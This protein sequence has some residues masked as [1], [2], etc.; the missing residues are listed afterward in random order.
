MHMHNSSRY[1]DR[2]ASGAS[3][4]E[5]VISNAVTPILGLVSGALAGS[6]E[7]TLTYPLT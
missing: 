7:T 1:S 5:A 4:N 2:L 6:L 3:L